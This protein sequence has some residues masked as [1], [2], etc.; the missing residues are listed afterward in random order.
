L[1]ENEEDDGVRAG[2]EPVGAGNGPKGFG[3]S[4][5]YK[6]EDGEVVVSMTK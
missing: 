2:A 5:E 3:V 6:A 4:G 1:E